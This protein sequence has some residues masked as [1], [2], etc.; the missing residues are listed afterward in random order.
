[1]KTISVSVSKAE[2]ETFR[3]LS[4][5]EHRPIAQLIR[6]AMAFYREHRL[7]SCSP[8]VDVPVLPGHRPTGPL[9][10]RAEV[11]DEISDGDAEGCGR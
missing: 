2:Y 4:K 10:G 5:R 9:Q 1:M 7:E 11:W 8:L 3:Q 6:E